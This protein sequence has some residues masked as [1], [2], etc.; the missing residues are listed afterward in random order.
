MVSPFQH[1]IVLSQFGNLTHMIQ[2]TD[3][4]G[5]SDRSIFLKRIFW[6]N[7]V[8]SLCKHLFYIKRCGSEWG[9]FIEFGTNFL[10]TW[11]GCTAKIGLSQVVQ[12]NCRRC[13]LKLLSFGI[14]VDG[15]IRTWSYRLLRRRGRCSPFTPYFEKFVNRASFSYCCF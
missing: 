1:H 9:R 2:S 13:S 8:V 10:F 12:Q 5:S 7:R 11:S 14:R 15:T 6:K 3:F 4:H